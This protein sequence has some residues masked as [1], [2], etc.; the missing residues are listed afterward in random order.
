MKSAIV[1]LAGVST[2]SQSKHYSEAEVPK[3]KGENADA[4]ERRT[5]RYRMHVTNDGHVQIPGT[6]IGNAIK[7]AAQ[8]LS[9]KVKGKGQATWTKN[10]RA[11]IMV[12]DGIV[13]P[14]LAKDVPGEELFVPANGKKGGGSRV[15]KVFPRIDDW[16][17]EVIVYIFD[18]TITEEVFAE[19]LATA[20]KL[21]GIGRF[22]PANGGFYGRFHVESIQWLSEELTKQAMGKAA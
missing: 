16:G 21:V 2:Y 13:L 17:G 11:G 7:D 5:W 18:D 20:G 14:V 19:V 15:P 1:H 6:Q 8:Y 12:P 9:L 3:E 4:Y 22:R 10:F